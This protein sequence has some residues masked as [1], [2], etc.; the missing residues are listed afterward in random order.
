MHAGAFLSMS[1][2]AVVVKCLMDSKMG[3]TEHGQVCKFY[4]LDL[5]LSSRNFFISDHLDRPTFIIRSLSLVS[6]HWR[7]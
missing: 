1:S 4:L 6:C 3:S 2:T 5:Y 7:R